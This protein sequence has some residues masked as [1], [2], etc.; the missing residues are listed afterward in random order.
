MKKRLAFKILIV[1]LLLCST[2]VC[3]DGYNEILYPKGGISPLVVSE[4][5]EN[6]TEKTIF[7]ITVND[8]ATIE[9][10]ETAGVQN[11]LYTIFCNAIQN[12]MKEVDISRF[13]IRKAD[14]EKII[15]QPYRYAALAYPQYLA[16]TKIGTYSE[17]GIMKIIYPYYLTADSNEF[18]TYRTQ[19][20]NRVDN[21]IKLSEKIPDDDIIGKILVIHDAFANE[22]TYA[23][24]ELKKFNEDTS[25]ISEYSIYTA[26]GGLVD[27][28]AVCQ[29]NAVALNM[30]YEKL[31]ERLKEKLGT[32]DDLIRTGICINDKICHMWNCIKIDGEWYLLDETWNDPVYYTDSGSVGN[33]IG[34]SHNYFL[35]SVERFVNDDVAGEN[36]HGN[37]SDWVLL[38]CKDISEN[39]SCTSKKYESGHIFNSKHKSTDENGEVT[40]KGTYHCVTSYSDGKYIIDMKGYYINNQLTIYGNFNNRLISDSVKSYGILLGEIY[41]NTDI[42]QNAVEYFITE[43]I[44]N[45]I[46]ILT[47]DYSEGEKLLNA[48]INEWTYSAVSG[49]IGAVKLGSN[50]SETKKLFLW[51]SNGKP[52]SESRA[53]K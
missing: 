32:E 48:E 14:A 38:C 19:M 36:A 11:E 44:D 23:A 39:I 33:S 51:D 27:K 1:M 3:A 35:T 18:E 22:N 25:D 6:E 34:A 45:P 17:N 28:N 52:V 20:N 43:D 5:E 21:Y 31:N 4:K 46:N 13:N 37:V 41:Y 24:E 42:K 26:Y 12:R 49:T 30:I 8:A 16:L 29:G 15:F 10:N 2:M 53:N 50:A 40:N 9:S 7:Q 47:A